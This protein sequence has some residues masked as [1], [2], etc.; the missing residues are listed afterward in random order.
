MYPNMITKALASARPTTPAREQPNKASPNTGASS[1]CEYHGLGPVAAP[2]VYRKLR[3][4]LYQRAA[5]NS[6]QC[7]AVSHSADLCSPRTAHSIMANSSRMST[8]LSV[9]VENVRKVLLPVHKAHRALRMASAGQSSCGAAFRISV[10]P[11]PDRASCIPV[12]TPYLA[13]FLPYHGAAS[14]STKPMTRLA[15]LHFRA[16]KH[17]TNTSGST[18]RKYALVSNPATSVAPSRAAVPSVG[19]P[20]YLISMD[21]DQT[22]SGTAN[23]SLATCAMVAHV[24]W[25]ERTQNIAA[26]LYVSESRR[27][28]HNRSMPVYRS[29]IPLSAAKIRSIS[30][31]QGSG[32]EES[33]RSG[34]ASRA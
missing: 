10:T 24:I 4:V 1:T 29:S 18:A 7:A 20:Q 14:S 25:H 8:E 31:R 33:A 3:T 9:H 17:A 5:E 26:L 19:A 12:I 22:V 13:R 28:L 11:I 34:T 27:S 15:A 21:S 30:T 6:T 2:R 32:T 16:Q 23:Q